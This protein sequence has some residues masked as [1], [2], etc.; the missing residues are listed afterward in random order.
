[1]GLQI[2]IRHTNDNN[3]YTQLVSFVMGGQYT[4]LSYSRAIGTV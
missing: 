4:N 3:A 2:Y 1:M